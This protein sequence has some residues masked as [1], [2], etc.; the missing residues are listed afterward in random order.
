MSK[1]LVAYFFAAGTTA[2]AAEK[3]ARETGAAVPEGK[4]IG[5]E[6]DIEALKVWEGEHD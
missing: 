3:P 4:R 6:A 2:K 5:G 1:A